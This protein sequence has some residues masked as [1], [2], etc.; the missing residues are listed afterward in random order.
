MVQVLHSELD[1]VCGD[2]IIVKIYLSTPVSDSRFI[3]GF[4]A[5][6]G[7]LVVCMYLVL[8]ERAD[9]K[10][11][12]IDMRSAISRTALTK[13]PMSSNSISLR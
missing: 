12:V 2:R 9:V 4:I 10:L 3:V 13:C 7:Y 11:I 6:P 8:G 5:V 1:M